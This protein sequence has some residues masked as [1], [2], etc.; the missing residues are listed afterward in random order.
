MVAENTPESN[1]IVLPFEGS[2]VYT[3]S[4]ENLPVHVVEV[5][6][7][8]FMDFPVCLATANRHD[9][10]KLVYLKTQFA[11]FLQKAADIV[12]GYKP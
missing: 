4:T 6:G 9:L 5:P 12:P 10:A 7:C 8:K 3:F 11:H 1:V 2:N